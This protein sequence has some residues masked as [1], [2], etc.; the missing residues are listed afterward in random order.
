MAAVAQALRQGLN[1]SG[2]AGGE[3][4][5]RLASRGNAAVCAPPS[6]ALVGAPGDA[7]K[8]RSPGSCI[9]FPGGCRVTDWMAENHGNL[10]PHHSGGWK[11]ET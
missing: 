1:R 10:C 4:G 7:A 9:R 8:G 3:G 11:P 6:R 2:A 5:P